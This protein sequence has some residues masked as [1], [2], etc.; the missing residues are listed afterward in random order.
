[1]R[2]QR[3][4]SLVEISLSLALVGLTTAMVARNVERNSQQL[5]AQAEAQTLA[6]VQKGLQG[7][8]NEYAIQ[9]VEQPNQP[10]E[11]TVRVSETTSETITL[12]AGTQVDHSYWPS[13]EKLRQLQ[14]LPASLNL[15]SLTASGR[16][17]VSGPIQVYAN[18]GDETPLPSAE[19]CLRDGCILRISAYPDPGADAISSAGPAARTANLIAHLMR[20]LGINALLAESNDGWL[21]SNSGGKLARSTSLMSVSGDVGVYAEYAVKSYAQRKLSDAVACPAGFFGFSASSRSSTD[22]TEYAATSPTRCVAPH[23][24]VPAGQQIVAYDNR[25]PQTGYVRLVCELSS[26][27]GALVLQTAADAQDPLGPTDSSCTP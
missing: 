5:L 19:F 24:Q 26:A 23:G 20:Q 2:S 18:A 13:L 7:Y 11:R 14:F 25:S 27:S 8:L 10:V 4:L 6:T 3:G 15:Q 22:A 9:L 1:M 12:P 21:Y 16:S 17:F